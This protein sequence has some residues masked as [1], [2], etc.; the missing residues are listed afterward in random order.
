MS[1]GRAVDVTA[2]QGIGT[3]PLRKEDRPLLRGEG[4]FAADFR[5]PGMVHA[6]FLRSPH[7][8]ARIN[9]ID[10][11]AALA[12]PGVIDVIT[13]ADLPDRGRPIPTRMFH[14]DSA[15]RFLQRPLADTVARYSGEPVAVVVA[16]TRYQAEDA[17]ELIDVDY[18]PLEPVLDPDAACAPGA[19]LLQPDA[20]TNVAGHLVVEMGSI[21]EAFESADLVVAEEFRVQRHGAVPLEPRGL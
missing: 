4:L 19:P 14:D 1:T 16:E 20:A 15:T 10:S 21:E 18:E 5:R 2:V 7:A 12:A 13:A 3:S 8:H 9:G 6:H 17:A 11:S